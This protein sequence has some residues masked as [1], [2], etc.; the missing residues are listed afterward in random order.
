MGGQCDF[1]LSC[2]ESVALYLGDGRLEGLEDWPRRVDGE[3]G[4]GWIPEAALHGGM[5]K[6]VIVGRVVT[7]VAS[8]ATRLAAP[9]QQEEAVETK[10]DN[11]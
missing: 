2:L 10:D 7:P 4:G 1:M 9:Q 11:H 5:A 6:W 8:R 3:V